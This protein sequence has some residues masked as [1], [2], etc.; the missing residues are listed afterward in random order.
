MAK[1][2]KTGQFRRFS[3]T[4]NT[5]IEKIDK[6]HN[7]FYNENTLTFE[8]NIDLTDQDKKDIFLFILEII[9]LLCELFI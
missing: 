4:E 3:K 8:D 1:N 9:Q 7:T 6:Y 2:N 5:L